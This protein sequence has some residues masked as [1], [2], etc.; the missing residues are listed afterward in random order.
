MLIKLIE[1]QETISHTNKAESFSK[2]HTLR[3]IVI[4]TDFIVTMRAEEMLESYIKD[5]PSAFDGLEKNQKF[6]RIAI[7]KGSM[8]ND[9]IILGSLDSLIKILDIGTKKVLKG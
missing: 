8:C 1:I 4:N 9:I 5:N 6:T 2:K 7:N 3:E